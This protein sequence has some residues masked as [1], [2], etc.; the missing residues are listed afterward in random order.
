MKMW[1][2]GCWSFLVLVLPLL[3]TAH[4]QEEE[5]GYAERV[6]DQ[7][8]QWLRS[9]NPLNDVF[10]VEG[11]A[12]GENRKWVQYGMEILSPIKYKRA[13]WVSGVF[14]P[15]EGVKKINAG[16]RE[17]LIDFGAGDCDRE[18][19]LTPDGD[20]CQYQHMWPGE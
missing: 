3:F 9:M 12:N 13:C 4:D 2:S 7:C 14:I 8:R 15:V 5:G 19:T 16:S 1:N 10:L 20:V 11:S 6:I 18:I 17:V